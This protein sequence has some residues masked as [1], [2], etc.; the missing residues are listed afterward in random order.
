[1]KV[2]FGTCH[3]IIAR[4]R[5]DKQASADDVFWDTFRPAPNNVQPKPPKKITRARHAELLD[6]LSTIK[7]MFGHVLHF[8]AEERSPTG[9][10]RG[11]VT[12]D[13][14]SC[15]TAL[16]DMKISEALERYM[17]EIAIDEVSGKSKEQRKIWKRA[18]GGLSNASLM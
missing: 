8:L 4:Q 2:A 5:R 16:S 3:I 9:P 7:L 15:F 1:M 14:T 17:S 18:N 13:N 11:K 12:S 10:E 6:E